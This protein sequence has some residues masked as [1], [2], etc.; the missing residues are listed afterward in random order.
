MTQSSAPVA[1][2][3]APAGL[4]SPTDSPA[5]TIR[6]LSDPEGLRH[7]DDGQ[8]VVKGLQQQPKSLPPRYFYD[9]RGSEL[10]EQ[11]CAQPEYYPTRTEDQILASIAPDI[12]RLTGPCELVELGSGSSTKTRQLLNAYQALG[13]PLR[14]VPVDVSDG[15]LKA[16][17]QQ[18]LQDYP[19]LQ[20][21]G[22]VGTYDQALGHLDPTPSPSRLL[23]FLGSSLGNFGPEACDRFLTQVRHA[24]QPGEYFLLGIDL[25]KPKAVLEAAYNDRQG[26][27][28]AFN[29]NVLHHL[30]WRYQGNLQPQNFEHWAF[31]NESAHQ[32]EMHLRCLHGHQAT[33]SGLGLTVDFAAGETLHTEIS[34]KFDREQMQGYL[35][36]RGLQPLQAWTDDRGWF[37]LILCQVPPTA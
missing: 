14:Y 25:Q 34:R 24:L 27:T 2:F 19:T 21:Q 12:A 32:I 23:F 3:P 30:N 17:A 18:L 33:L 31:Y 11:I 36:D 37:G 9:D 13:H 20:V 1:P 26:V 35:A 22:L 5:L 8:D 28:A 7:Q 4:V 29:L 16:S 10:F 6:Y 15:I